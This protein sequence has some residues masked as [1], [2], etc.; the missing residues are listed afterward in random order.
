MGYHKPMLELAEKL[1]RKAPEG[2]DS[3][4]CVLTAIL[5]EQIKLGLQEL[6]VIS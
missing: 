3:V 6:V 1:A 5:L 2:L 4:L